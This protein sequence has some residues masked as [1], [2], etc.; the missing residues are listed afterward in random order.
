LSDLRDELTFFHEDDL[1][2]VRGDALVSGLPAEGLR[3]ELADEEIE[4]IDLHVYSFFDFGSSLW[5]S[6]YEQTLTL[7]QR[8]FLLKPG[9]TWSAAAGRGPRVRLI[10]YKTLLPARLL[11]KCSVP[12]HRRRGGRIVAA[13]E[14]NRG[15]RTVLVAEGRGA[16]TRRVNGAGYTEVEMFVWR[17][18]LH[19]IRSSV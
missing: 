14:R 16:G 3:L 9:T 2:F 19:R 8:E 15:Y 10:R 12:R 11:W 18:C 4:S 17:Q 6:R 1:A 7:N 5:A 13:A